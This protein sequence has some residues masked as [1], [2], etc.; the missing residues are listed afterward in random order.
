MNISDV[1]RLRVV[2]TV[3]LVLAFSGLAPTYADVKSSEGMNEVVE[4]EDSIGDSQSSP[5][6]PT[7]SPS[8]F[9][10]GS[11]PLKTYTIDK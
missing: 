4:N 2:L 5:S 1:Q 10:A 11:G 6:D 8:S 3:A 9:P 7:D